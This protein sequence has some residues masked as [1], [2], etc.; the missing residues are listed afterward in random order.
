MEK[1]YIL[2]E[3]R[4]CAAENGGV[5]VGRA[6]FQKLT[7]IRETDWSGMHWTRWSDAVTEAGLAPNE[8]QE[9]FPEEHFL[10]ALVPLV[11]ELGRL[12]TH[13][14]MQM[15]RRSDPTFPSVNSFSRLGPKGQWARRLGEFCRTQDGFDDVIAVCEGLDDGSTD[16]V[17]PPADGVTFGTVYLMKSG[18]HYKIGRTNAVGR[19]EY[20]L[21]IQL[22]ERLVVVHTIRT[23]DP[24]GI[25]RYWHQR[26]ADR[27]ANGEWFALTASDI[28]AFRRRTFM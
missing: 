9:G 23:D 15:R 26:F 11:R 10:A 7:G 19:R 3:I 27:R 4:R 6:R 12:P 22:P 28:A 1:E 18:K 24:V 5:A 2:S 13:A 25:E 14:E 16:E 20:E 17:T 21:A 8:M